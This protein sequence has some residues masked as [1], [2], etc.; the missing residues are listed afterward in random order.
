MFLYLFVFFIISGIRVSANIYS[1]FIFYF[2]FLQIQTRVVLQAV[3]PMFKLLALQKPLRYILCSDMDDLQM[4][5]LCSILTWAT[6]FSFG[7]VKL[8]WQCVHS[9]AI[10]CFLC[11]LSLFFS[12]S[13]CTGKCWTNLKCWPRDEWC[14]EPTWY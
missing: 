1:E 12:S 8:S 4:N 5:Y 7:L 11:F 9:H 3:N 10:L 2:M 14:C 6:F 13:H